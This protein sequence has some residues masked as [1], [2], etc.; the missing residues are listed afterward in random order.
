LAGDVWHWKQTLKCFGSTIVG[1]RLRATELLRAHTIR[2]A[3]EGLQRRIDVG[4]RHE[5]KVVAKAK[6][7][8]VLD[9]SEESVLGA[10]PQPETRIQVRAPN[11]GAGK[12]HA[13]LND[14]ATLLRIGLHWTTL[15]GDGEPT[16]PRFLALDWLAAEV[17]G[18]RHSDA[19]VPE[20]LGDESMA[21]PGTFPEWRF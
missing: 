12:A 2:F 4:G 18:Q 7:S 21:A 13:R 5:T 11:D 10:A 1:R 6:R 16:V 9:A 15:T 17:L 14:D 20:I 19:G 8:K 3:D